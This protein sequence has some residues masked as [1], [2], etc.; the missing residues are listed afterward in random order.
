MFFILP[1]PNKFGRYKKTFGEVLMNK[2]EVFIDL[3]IEKYKT[4]PF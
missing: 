1:K 2:I 4:L 3:I